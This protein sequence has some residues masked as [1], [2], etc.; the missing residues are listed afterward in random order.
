MQ[1]FGLSCWPGCEGLAPA[2]SYYT[3]LAKDNYKVGRGM[4]LLALNVLWLVPDR[5]RRHFLTARPV[6]ELGYQDHWRWILIIGYTVTEQQ[7]IHTINA[8]FLSLLL[9]SERRLI[10]KA[11]ISL[12]IARGGTKNEEGRNTQ[13]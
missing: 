8:L 12:A 10:C 9:S 11:G 6:S 4:S 2:R 7:S 5:A 1:T 13:H 3:L